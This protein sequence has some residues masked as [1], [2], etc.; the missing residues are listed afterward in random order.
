MEDLSSLAKDAMWVTSQAA[1]NQHSSNDKAF[2]APGS[3]PVNRLSDR[4]EQIEPDVD[5]GPQTMPGTSG[6]PSA[7]ST[8]GDPGLPQPAWKKTSSP[9]VVRIPAKHPASA[10]VARG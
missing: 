2:A 9:D 10:E 7:R 1:G 8:A 4:D 5:L 6:K 3:M